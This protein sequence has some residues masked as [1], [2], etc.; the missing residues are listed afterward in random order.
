MMFQ[1][2]C[3][4]VSFWGVILVDSLCSSIT[5]SVATEINWP[6]GEILKILILTPN[7]LTDHPVWAMLLP[8]L[9]L[10]FDGTQSTLSIPHLFKRILTL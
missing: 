4:I 5:E 2:N 8:L 3:F 6:N 1:R 10:G 7:S 9:C